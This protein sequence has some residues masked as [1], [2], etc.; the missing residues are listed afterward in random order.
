MQW[1]GEPFMHPDKKNLPVLC[2]QKTARITLTSLS[3][4]E[5]NALANEKSSQRFKKN[6]RARRVKKN[7]PITGKSPRAL[8]NTMA[9]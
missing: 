3:F 5:C 1:L 2:V 8:I 9:L 6:L 4:A 7:S